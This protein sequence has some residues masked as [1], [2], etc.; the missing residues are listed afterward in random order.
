MLSMKTVIDK[1]KY[2]SSIA[3]DVYQPSRVQL[4]A[5]GVEASDFVQRVLEHCTEIGWDNIEFGKPLSGYAKRIALT[6]RHCILR[7]TEFIDYV[8]PD[9][10]VLE[11]VLDTTESIHDF[12][13]RLW[14]YLPKRPVCSGRTYREI[15]ERYLDCADWEESTGTSNWA[16]IGKVR[17]RIKGF[18]KYAGQDI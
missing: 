2:V 13:E 6:T 12:L 16:T 4:N 9:S 14:S 7:R 17:Q 15:I 3:L 5:L 18:I 8:E 10:E 1:I 11:C